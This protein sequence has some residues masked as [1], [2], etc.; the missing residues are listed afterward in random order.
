MN[1]KVKHFSD[2]GNVYK[3]LSETHWRD[4]ALVSFPL[5]WLAKTFCETIAQKGKKFHNQQWWL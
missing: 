1:G 3:L 5:V 4:L 2:L